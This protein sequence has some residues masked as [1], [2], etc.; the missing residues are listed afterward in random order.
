MSFAVWCLLKMLVFNL[1]SG[2]S[3]WKAAVPEF[4]DL[5]MENVALLVEGTRN[6]PPKR[7]PCKRTLWRSKV[8]IKQFSSVDD[9]M[10]IVPL[11]SQ[12]G[13]GSLYLEACWLPRLLYL[14]TIFVSPRTSSPEKPSSALRQRRLRWLA[15]WDGINSSSKCKVKKLYIFPSHRAVIG[16]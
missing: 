15:V 5:C 14:T 8:D 11:Q 12:R 3:F 9:A 16:E 2:F 10:K 7:N 13:A 4:G 1:S 6:K